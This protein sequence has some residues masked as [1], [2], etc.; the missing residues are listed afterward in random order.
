M[1]SNAPAVHKIL[2]DGEFLPFQDDMFDLVISNL[3]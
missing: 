2:C 3:R 1:S